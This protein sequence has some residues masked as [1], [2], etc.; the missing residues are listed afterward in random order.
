M[1][2]LWDTHFGFSYKTNL[3]SS[4]LIYYNSLSNIFINT[5]TNLIHI[6]HKYIILYN[7]IV[8]R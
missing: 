3:N 8:S 4:Y 5:F 1:I 7:N 2:N 6:Y